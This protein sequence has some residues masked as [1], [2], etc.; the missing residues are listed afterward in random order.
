MR[1]SSILDDARGVA[2]L[3]GMNV[4]SAR[5]GEG[6]KSE[7]R[8]AI[9]EAMVQVVAD[10]GFHGA[11][12]ALVADRAAVGAG[13]IYRYFADKDALIAA[14]YESVE[15]RTLDAVWEGY[16]EDGTIRERLIH[17]TTRMIRHFIDHQSDY[18]FVQHF[19]DSPYG[20]EHRR[21]MMFGDEAK[22]FIRQLFDEG[23]EGG[24]LKDLPLPIL[25]GLTF[26]PVVTICREHHLG[27]V[28]LDERLIAEI[29]DACW[30]A[31]RRHAFEVSDG[32]STERT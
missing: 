21:E 32:P 15:A 11:P 2:T 13:T 4:H 30:D 5:R 18:R 14:C 3:L 10:C 31:S 1:P 7:K 24:I 27:F 23:K 16:H 28:R 26:G 22:N 29:A 9:I 6:P 17:V 20:A 8:R 19:H 25:F 12:V